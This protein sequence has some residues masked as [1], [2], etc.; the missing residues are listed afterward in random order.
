MDL[1]VIVDAYH[2]F[3]NPAAMLA[4]IRDSLRPRGDR[5]RGGLVALFEI[6]A[7]L[8]THIPRINFHSMDLD[9]ILLEWRSAGFDPIVVD[10]SMAR[11]HFVLFA[12]SADPPGR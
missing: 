9:Q 6:K 7:E 3:Q 2:E 5:D 12:R 10:E 1:I 8:S 4:S 11:I